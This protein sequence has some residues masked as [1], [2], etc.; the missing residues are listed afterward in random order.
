MCLRVVNGAVSGRIWRMLRESE[1]V[2]LEEGSFIKLGR[3]E[4]EVKELVFANHKKSVRS[5]II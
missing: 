1:E 3:V 2:E 4:L 5:L